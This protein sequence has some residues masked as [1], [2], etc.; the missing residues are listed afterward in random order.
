MFTLQKA[1]T[2]E[3]ALTSLILGSPDDPVEL[4]PGLSVHSVSLNQPF[5]QFDLV[6]TMAES[7][8]K[9]LAAQ[10][11]YNTDLF[12]DATMVRFAGHLVNLM[13]AAVAGPDE[14]VREH[15]AR[16]IRHRS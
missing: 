4:G 9:G 15:D 7:G 5:T 3:D 1:F 6:L 16:Q 12:A 13:E 11:Q 8:T 10:L 14:Q 2:G